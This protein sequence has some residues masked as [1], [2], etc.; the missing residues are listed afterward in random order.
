LADTSDLGQKFGLTVRTIDAELADQYNNAN[1]DEGVV[2]VEVKPGSPAARA[3]I[4]EGMVILEV[5]RTEVS[6]VGEFNEAIQDSE[7]TKKA[8]LLVKTGRYAQYVVLQIRE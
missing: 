1:E 8:M 4:R 2:V 5:N 3:G 6:D 7:E